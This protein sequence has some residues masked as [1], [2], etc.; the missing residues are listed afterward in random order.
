[1]RN[2]TTLKLNK[3]F[4][5][6]YYNA[7]YK[8]HPLVVTYA[9]RNKRSTGRYGISTAKKIGNAVC[10]NRAKRVITAALTELEKEFDLRRYDLVFAA[11]A[12]TP[13]ANSNAVR[14]VIRKH[15]NLLLSNS[16]APL[17]NRAKPNTRQNRQIQ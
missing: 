2:L 3:E 12:G 10:R 7:P 9:L 1:M 4:K 13:S 16:Q 11:R 5:R 6:V 8:A 14:D 15:L 17:A